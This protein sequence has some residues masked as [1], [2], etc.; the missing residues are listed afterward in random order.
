M[1]KFHYNNGVPTN[2]YYNNQV[3]NKVFYT[4]AN[5]NNTEVWPLTPATPTT[6]VAPTTSIG[7]ALTEVEVTSTGSGQPFM[8]IIVNFLENGFIEIRSQEVT[9][10][11]GHSLNTTPMHS[12][13]IGY[14]EPDPTMFI[15]ES[16]LREFK[17]TTSAA[18]SFSG[19]QF[20]CSDNQ[21]TG[22]SLTEGG[23]LSNFD[24]YYTYAYQGPGTLGFVQLRLDKNGMGD[25][26]NTHK[27]TIKDPTGNE[28]SFSIDFSIEISA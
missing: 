5:G 14:S 17:W 27:F 3:V 18:S 26:S 4:D 16:I 12:S 9:A 13:S 7:T 2:V 23:V 25:A 15:Q 6:P 21:G 24:N 10:I 28:A 20:K 19:Y 1:T 8:R 11:S 22:S